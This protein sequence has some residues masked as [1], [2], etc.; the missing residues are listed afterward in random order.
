M[1]LCTFLCVYAAFVVQAATA[2]QQAITKQFETEAK[3]IDRWWQN[4]QEPLPVKFELG[5]A[6]ACTGG[7]LFQYLQDIEEEIVE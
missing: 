4:T 5:A 6:L 7:V 3:V 2:V 1:Q